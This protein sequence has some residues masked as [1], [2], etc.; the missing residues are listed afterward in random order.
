MIPIE[1]AAKKTAPDVGYPERYRNV[2]IVHK[3]KKIP[4]KKLIKDTTKLQIDQLE[5]YLFSLTYL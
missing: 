1:F 2:A 3:I 4:R 5:L